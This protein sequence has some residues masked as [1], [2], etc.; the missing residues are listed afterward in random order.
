MSGGLLPETVATL[1]KHGRTQGSPLFPNLIA[2]ELFDFAHTLG[3]LRVLPRTTGDFVVYD[4]SRKFGD[5]TVSVHKT[6]DEADRA[7]R[8]K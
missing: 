8:A 3:S 2:G 6:A 7:M 1:A 5:R 4:G